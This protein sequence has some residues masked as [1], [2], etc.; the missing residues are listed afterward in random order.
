MPRTASHLSMWDVVLLALGI[1]RRDDYLVLV[2]L[3][4]LL[5]LG[6]SFGGIS[7]VDVIVSETPPVLPGMP[8]VV[9]AALT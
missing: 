3:L 6:I 7:Q 1:R 2:L 5:S 9:K 8:V 4:T